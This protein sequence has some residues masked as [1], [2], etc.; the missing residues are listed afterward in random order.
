[1]PPT[2]AVVSQVF[3]QIGLAKL[4]GIDRQVT[5]NHDHVRCWQ[6]ISNI[7]TDGDATGQ[8]LERLKDQLTKEVTT[9]LFVAVTEALTNTVHHSALA[10]RPDRIPVLP[11]RWWMFAGVRDNQLTMV[12]CDL[13]IGIPASVPLNWKDVPLRR[14]LA[15]LGLG[16]TDGAIIQLSMEIRR[17][18][19]NKPHRGL[20]MKQL[21]D[22]LTQ[23]GCGYLV[24]YSNKGVYA[25]WPA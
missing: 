13:G 25:Y 10:Q 20:G 16:S 4:I 3:Q 1:M 9:E 24:V 21:R 6:F 23:A 7:T 15:N 2:D 14:L 19:T 18:V 11:K 12:V 22:V 17:T 5:I 8:I